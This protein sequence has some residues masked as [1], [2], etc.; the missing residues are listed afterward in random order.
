[1]HGS[2]QRAVGIG[3]DV[4]HPGSLDATMSEFGLVKTGPSPFFASG[5]LLDC[6]GRACALVRTMVSAFGLDPILCY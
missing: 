2:D 3:G 1:V 6:S 4:A 5:C